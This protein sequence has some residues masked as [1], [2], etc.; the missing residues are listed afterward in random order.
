[1]THILI[2]EDDPMVQFIHKTYLEKINSDYLV[3]SSSTIKESLKILKDSPIDLIL[4]DIHLKDGNGLRL[5]SELRGEKQD[6]DVILIT[7]SK[8]AVIVKES[9]HLGVLDYLIKPFTFERFAKSLSLYQKKVNQL[10]KAEMSQ[11]HIDSFLQ[12]NLDNNIQIEE[13]MEKGLTPETLSLVIKII[14]T[15]KEPFTIQ[16]LTQAS[17]LSHVSIRKYVA[18]LEKED[19]LSSKNIYLKKGRPYKVYS[20]KEDKD[21]K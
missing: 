14:K 2:I 19:Q 10:N 1:M 15:L 16:E 8:E 5:L 18:Y 4:L 13:E 7:A 9:L 3:Y 17:K 12:P 11:T 20:W 6:V 21:T